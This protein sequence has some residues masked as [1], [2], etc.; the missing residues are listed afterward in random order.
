MNKL[1]LKN[2][3]LFT[4]LVT[5]LVWGHVIWDYFH[6]GVPTHYLFHDK[7]M[8]GI[9]NWVGA[10]ILPFFT[11]FLLYRIQKRSDAADPNPGLKLIG[12][13]FLMAALVAIGIAV[14]FTLGI[15]IP[16]F[17][18]LSILG[19]GLFFPLYYSEFLLGWVLGSAFTFGAVIPM[20]F[21]SL[22]ALV[23]FLLFLIGSIVKKRLVPK[24]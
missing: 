1:T 5:L 19:L 7:D 21:G 9:P 12:L 4:L 3:L 20:G 18:L 23:C 10:I 2:R 24:T 13:R 15:E 6:G 17:I 22:F 16:G 11:W 14:C 8:P